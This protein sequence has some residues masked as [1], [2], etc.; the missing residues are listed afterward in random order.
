[1]YNLNLDTAEYY[2]KEAL[3]YSSSSYDE[4]DERVASNHYIL[5]FSLQTNIQQ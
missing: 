3:A 2:L 5:S 1:M 4:L